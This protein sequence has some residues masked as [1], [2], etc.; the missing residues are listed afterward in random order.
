MAGKKQPQNL[1]NID[2]AAVHEQLTTILNGM[3]VTAEAVGAITAQLHAAQKSSTI[4]EQWA[5]TYG[6]TLPKRA[7][8][9]ML[10]VSVNHLVKLVGEGGIKQTPDGRIVVRSAAEWANGSAPRARGKEFRV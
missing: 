6:E 9:E 7:A 3:Q 5:L 4:G 2:F 1:A 8:A 10:G